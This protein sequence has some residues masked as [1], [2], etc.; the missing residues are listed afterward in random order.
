MIIREV[1]D[2]MP[3]PSICKRHLQGG[4]QF[5][6]KTRQGLVC[7]FRRPRPL[8]SRR[9]Q[10]PALSEGPRYNDAKTGLVNGKVCFGLA[11]ALKMGVLKVRNIAIVEISTRALDVVLGRGGR[12]ANL[13]RLWA[14][15]RQRNQRVK[16]EQHPPYADPGALVYVE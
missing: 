9:S 4:R 15:V 6:Y 5:R 8:L 13:Q 7:P 14:P 3:R 1:E 11:N 10:C 2:G 12:T 16:L